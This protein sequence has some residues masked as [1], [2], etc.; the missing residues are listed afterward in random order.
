MLHRHLFTLANTAVA[1]AA[2]CTGNNNS[3]LP[4]QWRTSLPQ[5]WDHMIARSDNE[6]GLNISATKNWALDQIMD[7]QG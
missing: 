4:E 7:G 1:V 5:V 3:T 6:V 2:L